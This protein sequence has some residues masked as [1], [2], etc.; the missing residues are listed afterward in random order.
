MAI[1]AVST[2]NRW[3][4][5]RFRVFQ[6]RCSLPLTRKIALALGLAAIIGLAA[7]A[8]IPV[9]WSPVPVTLQTFAVLLAAV[10]MGRWWGG[11][12]VAIYVGLGAAGLPWFN[13]WAGGIGHLAGPTG[14]FLIGF[15]LVALFVGH[16]SDKYI[17][18]RSFLGMFGL[19]VFANF[20]LI[21]IPGLT[22]LHLWLSLVQ[23]QPAG[24]YQLLAMGLLPFIAGDIAKVA[25]AATI[26]YGIT[27]KK[28]YY[29]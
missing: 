1:S 19:M 10:M 20:V 29:K 23:G 6:W 28:P 26:A 3:E 13:G 18:A 27:P 5:L 14:G 2:W 9:P 11:A 7:Q 21:Y 12:S 17:Q 8:R 15:I 25:A 22:Q 4:M 16:F 24:F